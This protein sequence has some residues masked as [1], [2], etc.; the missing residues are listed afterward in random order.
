MR[1]LRIR[2]IGFTLV[3]LLVVIG[4]IAVL[5]AIL[6]PALQRAKAQANDVSC[7][8]NLKQIALAARLYAQENQDRVPLAWTD[9][10][11][12]TTDAATRSH[13]RTNWHHR[14][15]PYMGYRH[16]VIESIKANSTT[17]DNKYNKLRWQ[18][19]FLCPSLGREA[20]NPSYAM[21]GCIGASRWSAH[22]AWAPNPGKAPP[23]WRLSKVQNPANVFL[24]G[25]QNNGN[26]D[27][28][29]SSDS[30]TFTNWVVADAV[31]GQPVWTNGD[32][33][34]NYQTP[35]GSPVFPQ[36][37]Y[38]LAA[39]PGFRHAKN[40]RANYAMVDG[41]V[42]ALDVHQTRFQTSGGNKLIPPPGAKQVY[43][44]WSPGYPA[45]Y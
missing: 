17:A 12:F 38:T 1:V 36:T 10:N 28:L 21:N 14:L 7:Q 9:Y 16:D 22:V 8:S 30:Y 24:Y 29:Q 19:L 3:E 43:R 40:L 15:L 34:D 5:I 23:N 2:A 41:H 26:N 39:G 31:T 35:S 25:D 13:Y 4:I 6:L 27:Y 44:W 37:G 20:T 45:G 18:G 33:R 32:T 42:E 11:A